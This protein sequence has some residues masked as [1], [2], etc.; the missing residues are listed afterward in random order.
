MPREVFRQSWVWTSGFTN[1]V[2]S[3]VLILIYVLCNYKYF[4]RE[5]GDPAP[6]NNLPLGI[7]FLIL[8]FCSALIIEHITIYAFILAIFVLLYTGLIQ[9]KILLQHVLYAIGVLLGTFLMFSNSAYYVVAEGDDNYRSLFE[10]G[11]VNRILENYKIIFSHG[12]AT[13]TL[14]LILFI[15]ILTIH[16]VNT[17]QNTGSKIVYG[18]FVISTSFLVTANISMDILTVSGRMSI[19]LELAALVS[20]F[21][22]IVFSIFIGVLNKSVW[23]ILLFA[24]SACFIIAPL[25][26]VQPIGPRNFFPSYIFLILLLLELI[27]LSPEPVL[28]FLEQGKYKFAIIAIIVGVFSFYSVIY[29]KVYTS[30]QA[31]IRAIH[32]AVDRGETEI[33]VPGLPYSE[34]LWLANPTSKSKLKNWQRRYKEMYDIPAEVTLIPKWV[35]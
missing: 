20:I 17:E 27:I 6:Q 16:F 3:T 21:S 15:L 4:T 35:K 33:E 25:F 11:L 10:G 30:E 28:N 32:E 24:G 18:C 8:G 29:V 31:R 26:V 9:H 5:K 34:Y 12:Y 14:L 13:Y 2:I 7:F 19:L 1:Y 22:L 23:Q